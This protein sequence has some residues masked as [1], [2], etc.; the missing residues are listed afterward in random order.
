MDLSGKT[1]LLL[2]ESTAIDSII[3]SVIS[4]L[5]GTLISL[6]F[7][8]IAEI[9]TEITSL[10]QKVGAVDGFIH[11]LVRSDFRPL[12]FVKPDLVESSMN[13]NYG[14]FI[15][16]VRILI[17][18]KGIRNNSSIV[19]LSSVSSVKAMKAKMAFCSAKAALDAAVRCLAVEL[20]EKGIRVNSIQKG[21]LDIDFEKDH[22]KNITS[23]R[24]D[25]CDSVPPLGISD[26][27]EIANLTAFLLSDATKT[28]T[29]TSITLDGGL[30]A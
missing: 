23:V 12:K 20:A 3:E 10:I 30:I 4:E 15:E 25:N 13:L 16:A 19:T 14:S 2:G 27:K 17:K 7:E 18:C 1:F 21:Y 24:K 29:G 5:G 8:S 22:I 9:G 26:A 6:K 28:L 11:T